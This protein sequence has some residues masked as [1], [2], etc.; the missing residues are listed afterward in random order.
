MSKSV[1]IVSDLSY[2]RP[3]MIETE[4]Q[5]RLNME[6]VCVQVCVCVCGE[7]LTL[8]ES[9]KTRYLLTGGLSELLHS[10]DGKGMGLKEL[11]GEAWRRF[12]VP[13]LFP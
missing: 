13:D 7:R 4:W 8:V 5:C 10:G 11:G 9:R 1:N 12:C 6:S 3:D 2:K